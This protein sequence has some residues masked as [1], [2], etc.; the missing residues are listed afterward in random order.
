MILRFLILFVSLLVLLTTAQIGSATPSVSAPS[1]PSHTFHLPIN[2]SS[3]AEL[4]AAVVGGTGTASDPYIIEG[5]N[6]TTNAVTGIF[7]RDTTAYFIIRNCWISTSVNAG[8][9]IA[10]VREWTAAV[11]NTT[12]QAGIYGII[13]NVSRYSTVVN[14]IFSGCGIALVRSLHSIVLNNVVVQTRF[15]GTSRGITLEESGN[16]TLASNILI[17]NIK[18]IE[19]SASGNS[20][21]T[22]NTCSRNS[23]GIGI[24]SPSCVI[25]WNVLME[26]RGYGVHVSSENNLLH[27]NL[28]LLNSYG[29]IQAN[30]DGTNNR[31]YEVSSTEG[32]YWSH[33]NQSEPYPIDGTAGVSDPYPLD[34]ADSDGDG[35]PDWYETRIGLD[36]N[37]DDATVDLDQDG[38][39]NLDEYQLG[40]NVNYSDTDEDGLL[41]GAEVHDHHTNPRN[42]DSDGDGLMDGAE[43][44]TYGTDPLKPDTDEDGLTEGAEVH[45]YGTDPLNPDTDEDG[46]TDGAEVHTHNTNPNN[47]DTDADGLS[48][49]DEIIRYATNPR[50]ADSDGD[51][52]T[53]G[54]EVK[55]YNSD[56]NDPD[57]DDDFF[58]DGWDYGWWG[59][60]RVN[61][62]NPL[63]RGLL[64]SLLAGLFGLAVWAGFIARQLP[65]LKQALERQYQHVQRQVEQLQENINAITALESRQELQEACKSIH[66]RFMTAR[67]TIQATRRLVVRKW[68]PLFLRP[69]LRPLETIVISL[70][71]MYTQFSQSYLSYLEEL[72]EE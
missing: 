1:S 41:D 51:G 6:I 4:A 35:L 45:T 50:R 20:T 33:H 3:D 22:N 29:G 46:L 44:H 61:W 7:I 32:N 12:C 8:I 65:P 70:N 9:Y 16:S 10:N 42:A 28:F 54:A 24:F 53:D 57:S 31:W 15:L 13:L 11:A 56:P 69:D 68:L 38:L 47:S 39:S 25:T 30:D 64:I 23:V 49:R 26:N 2:V 19:I 72:W 34:Y 71:R 67:E 27:N 37:V 58:P 5:W 17:Q 43:V 62:D 63:A 36:P 60:P 59:N 52:L 48:D 21:L 18:G 66:Q 55:R 40:T 14:N